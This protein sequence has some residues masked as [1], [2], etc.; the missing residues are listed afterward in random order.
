MCCE[1]KATK[2][3]Y[4]DIYGHV[5]LYFPF[6]VSPAPLET[7]ENVIFKNAT[8]KQPMRKDLRGAFSDPIAFLNN[9]LVCL[10]KRTDSLALCVAKVTHCVSSGNRL[11]HLVVWLYKKSCTKNWSKHPFL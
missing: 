8:A 7:R 2:L 4:A 6:Q 1:K 5:L 3:H 10:K 9:F 11:A